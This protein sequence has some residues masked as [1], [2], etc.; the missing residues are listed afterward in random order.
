MSQAEPLKLACS[1]ESIGVITDASTG[2]KIGSAFITDRNNDVVSCAHV[3]ADRTN[4]VYDSA[5]ATNPVRRLKLKYILPRF[6]LAVL[7]A[8]KTVETKPLNLGDIRRIRP[9]DRI[10][11]VGY[12][13]GTRIL[14]ASAATVTATGAALN[15]GAIVEF[16][17]F[18][19]KGMP[20]YSGG[21]VFDLDCNVV[22]VMRE[23]WT[24]R[25]VKGGDTLLINRAFSVGVL[26]TLEGEVYGRN[27]TPQEPY[28]G[29]LSLIEVS[30]ILQSTNQEKK[31]P[32]NASEAIVP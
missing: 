3:V 30:G 29:N 26:K 23:A 16:L 15:D 25:G 19:G 24:K 27:L 2:Q 13:Q 22:A 14:N 4:L 28:S 8:E 32:N 7:T 21:P 1:M 11:Y 9:G 6:D 5:D 10:M 31:T 18:Q 20:G 12:V 17:E